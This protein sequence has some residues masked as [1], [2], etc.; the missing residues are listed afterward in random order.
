MD[1]LPLAARL[2]VSLALL[3][4]LFS[5]VGALGLF[6]TLKV[7]G[8]RRRLVQPGMQD[9]EDSTNT[10][11]TI[12]W[13]ALDTAGTAPMVLSSH[14]REIGVPWEQ[15]VLARMSS[16]QNA[17]RTMFWA[18][19]GAT[20]LLFIGLFLTG[21]W[22]AVAAGGVVTALAA[23][24][25][26]AGAGM[27]DVHKELGETAVYLHAWAAD[28]PQS[29]G[30]SAPKEFRTVDQR[31]GSLVSELVALWEIRNGGIPAP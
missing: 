11:M 17:R 6:Q 23:A 8:Y 28:D 25:P 9:I 30:N 21:H 2:V 15:F 24:I 10:V 3:A 5:F 29:F 19:N 13:S 4:A 16:Y 22:I 26:L 1:L 27:S 12:V 31:L 14:R 7:S 18:Q 20:A